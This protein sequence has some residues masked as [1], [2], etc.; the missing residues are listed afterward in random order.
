MVEMAD[1]ASSVKSVYYRNQ[2]HLLGQSSLLHIFQLQIST[3]PTRSL[4]LF[5]ND[6]VCIYP[7]DQCP[8]GCHFLHVTPQKNSLREVLGMKSSICV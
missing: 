8:V 2:L 7:V 1:N 4:E 3:D 6:F 5:S